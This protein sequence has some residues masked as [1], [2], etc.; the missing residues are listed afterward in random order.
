[1]TAFISP[2]VRAACLALAC[3]SLP[4]A[5]AAAA[6]PTKPV[7]LFRF[8]KAGKYLSYKH[9]SS[10]HESGSHSGRTRVYVNPLLFKSLKQGKSKHPVGAAA[11][12]ELYDPSGDQLIGWAVMVKVKK[13]SNGGAGW[14]WYETFDTEDPDNFSTSG[15]GASQCVGCHSGG[16]DM[17]Q[18]PFPLQ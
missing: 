7:K 9:E 14:Y 17:I 18:S 16:R 6:V 3:V 15:R 8:L 11:V 12:K 13:N 2:R 4:I 10:V 1:M 5:V